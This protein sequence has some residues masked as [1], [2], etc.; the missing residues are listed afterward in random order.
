[1]GLSQKQ[2]GETA[3]TSFVPNTYSTPNAFVDQLM[4]LLE[5]EEYVVL[6]YICRHILGWQDKI[7]RRIGAV[8]LS[9]LEDGFEAKNGDKYHGCGLSKPTIQKH[10]VNLVSFNILTKVGDPT[11]EG[12]RYYIPVDDSEIAYASLNARLAEKFKTNQK[13]TKQAR[14]TQVVNATN[15]PKAVGGLSDIPGVVNATNPNKYNTK[16]SNTNTSASPSVIAATAGN[17]KPAIPFPSSRIDRIVGNDRPAAA[18]LTEVLTS[19]GLLVLAAYNGDSRILHVAAKDEATT[20][21]NRQI[22]EFDPLTQPPTR[23]WK[24]SRHCD[25]CAK[26][27]AADPQSKSQDGPRVLALEA[28]KGH[29]LFFMAADLGIAHAAKPSALRAVCGEM[30]GSHLSTTPMPHVAY[31]LCRDC[32]TAIENAPKTVKKAPQP[33]MAPI[34]AWVDAFDAKAMPAA[35]KLSSFARFS[36]DLFQSGVLPEQMT[37]AAELYTAWLSAVKVKP[38][39]TW[40]VGEVIENVRRALQLCKN[41]VTAEVIQKFVKDCY[42]DAWWTG[43]LVSFKHV[44]DNIVVVAPAPKAAAAKANPNCEK[45][46]GSGLETFTEGNQR[47][48][49]T[50]SCVKAVENVG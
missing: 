18:Q 4:H 35:F 45:C 47:T 50:C 36:R 43:K 34:V 41:G 42:A 5:P 7:A 32:S 33:H 29:K 17:P 39:L 46:S 21:C 13:R 48:M 15:H 12:Q 6:S 37:C 30:L 1:M 11:P 27:R 8:S 3:K 22:G 24:Y 26:N 25:D 14:K 19:D 9:M 16:T 10:L 2:A 44:G 20:L 40:S 23:Q 28:P 31:T 38:T 49:R